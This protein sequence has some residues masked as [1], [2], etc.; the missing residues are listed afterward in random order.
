ME[1]PAGNPAADLG[2]SLR[3]EFARAAVY[4]L[5]L[6]I[7]RGVIGSLPFLKNGAFVGDT[8]LSPLVLVNVAI[9]TVFLAVLLSFGLTA[10]RRIHQSGAQLADVGKI[11]SLTTVVIVLVL[12]YR[13]YE[14]PAACT[15]LSQSDLINL[16]TIAPQSQDAGGFG[17][18]IRLWGQML[19]QVSAASLQNASGPV[20]IQYQ[21]L[22]LAIF[23]RSPDWYAWLFLILTAIPIISL[24]PLVFRNLGSLSELLSHGVLTLQTAAMPGA[25]APAPAA[26]SASGTSATAPPSGENPA[27]I[28]LR[29]GIER[30]KTLNSLQEAGAISHED[31]ATQKQRMLA[32]A[33]ADNS[34]KPDADDFLRLKEAYDTSILTLDEYISLKDHFLKRI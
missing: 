23:H 8:L 9:D 21:R 27:S 25:G 20:L 22:A 33:L 13:I 30:L 7:L 1:E 11:T 29:D 2:T 24:A 18:F 12:A 6:L 4:G 14:L 3:K 34:S 19:N 16:S 5:F 31:F 32:S 10:G 26:T 15:F 28:P 17:D